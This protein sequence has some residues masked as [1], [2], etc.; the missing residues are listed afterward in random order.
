[1]PRRNV[2][3]DLYTQKDPC[4]E[5][6]SDINISHMAGRVKPFVRRRDSEECRQ[7]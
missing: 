1:L 5:G 7:Y 6:I 3:P 4:S 2:V